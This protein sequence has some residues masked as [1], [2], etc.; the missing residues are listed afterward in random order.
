VSRCGS[1]IGTD[2]TSQL[3][4]RGHHERLRSTRLREMGVVTLAGH[5]DPLQQ[6]NAEG[7]GLA[8]TGASLTNHVGASQGNRNRQRLDSKWRCDANVIEGLHNWREYAKSG[9]SFL[10]ALNLNARLCVVFRCCFGI[11]S[12]A[13]MEGQWV[14][15][16]AY[17]L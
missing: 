10:L 16:G 5:H 12:S 14:A 9:E 17:P 7:Q 3:S 1:K 2:L 15:T 4:G 13:S 11:Q 8:G 6:R